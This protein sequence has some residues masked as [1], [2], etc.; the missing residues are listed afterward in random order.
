MIINKLHPID[1]MIESKLKNKKFSLQFLPEL[2]LEISKE[3]KIT[4]KG[5]NLKT[6]YL[7]DIVHN[8]MLKYFFKRENSFPLN[9]IVLKERYGHL[10]NFYIRYLVL[11]DII[12]MKR[13]Y[14]KGSTSRVYQLSPDIINGKIH[15]FRNAD[16]ILLKK[17]VT[18]YYKFEVSINDIIP[19]EIKDIL[20]SDLYNV[21]VDYDKALWYLDSL[22]S[23]DAIY[24]RN[25]YSVDSINE[26][27][28][29]YH[30]DHYGRMHTNFTI[31]K[32]FIRKNCLLIDGK[33]TCEFDIPNS[34]PLFLSKLI[35]KSESRWIRE[36]EFLFFKQL[37]KHG[38]FYQFLM[39]KLNIE[40]KSKAKELTYKVLFGKNHWNS[41]ADKEFAKLF[42]SIHYFIKL[43]KKDKGDYR[44]LAYDLQKMESGFIYKDVI[45]KI[46]MLGEIP[47]VTV[48]D[49]IITTEDNREIVEDIFTSRM[50]SYFGW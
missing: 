6:A 12:S 33:K 8:M 44:I 28:I 48:H 9:S 37:L 20:I 27:H 36:D 50:N 13:Q 23:Q 30:F 4:F 21:R 24:E 39:D 15:R 38:N 42:P 19:K 41:K 45:S 16:K 25:K 49:S 2:L 29:F 17:Y 46:K 26:N 5:R 7:I 11:N 3:K 43:Y 31:L 10:Y 47:I 32:S 1:T 34:Q 40:T 14:K 22:K 35:E 18:R